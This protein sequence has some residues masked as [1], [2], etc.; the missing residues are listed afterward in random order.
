MERLVGMAAAAR[1][2]GEHYDTF[3]KRWPSYVVDAADG[4]P[5]PVKDCRPYKWR[6]SSLEAWQARR[7][8]ETAA[9][10]LRAATDPVVA[11]NDPRPAPPPRPRGLAAARD[12][13]RAL[14][15]A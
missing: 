3:R 10:L 13:I 8:A 1:A 15:R 7:E 9:A 2:R 12:E 6:P 5:A 4:F 14:M 11:A